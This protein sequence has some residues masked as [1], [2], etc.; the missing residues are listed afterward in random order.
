[1]F[2]A[3]SNRWKWKALRARAWQVLITG[4]VRS[5]GKWWGRGGGEALAEGDGLRSREEG[6]MCFV[7]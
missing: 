2:R 3:G 4:A 6:Q 7:F 5:E 1:M